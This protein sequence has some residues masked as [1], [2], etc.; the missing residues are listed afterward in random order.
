MAKKKKRRIV[1]GTYPQ[2]W[3][4][5]VKKQEAKVLAWQKAHSK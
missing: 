4:D 3:K 1:G 5:F 2:E